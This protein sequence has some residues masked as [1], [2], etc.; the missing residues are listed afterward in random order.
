MQ[1]LLSFSNHG[2]GREMPLGTRKLLKKGPLLWTSAHPTKFS[3]EN[4][5]CHWCPGIP[6]LPFTI[7][8]LWGK[9]YSTYTTRHNTLH[10]SLHLVESLVKINNVAASQPLE[11]YFPERVMPY[12]RQQGYHCHLE[13]AMVYIRAKGTQS[14]GESNGLPQRP[15]VHTS[16][17][18]SE[19]LHSRPGAS[20]SPENRLSI[21]SYIYWISICS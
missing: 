8:E 2:Q 21:P 18:G 7:A 20:T 15:R 9:P 4:M 11:I 12:I 17:R 6:F 3:R 10:S 19:A 13:R 14:P 1:H 5:S 16:S